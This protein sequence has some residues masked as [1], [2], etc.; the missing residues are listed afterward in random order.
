MLDK[1]IFR[2][3]Y[4]KKR[5]AINIQVGQEEVRKILSALR[6]MPLYQ[7]SRKIFTYYSVGS[8]VDTKEL[9]RLALLE[10]KEIYLPVCG[11]NH[12]MAIYKI[13]SLTDIVEG[14]YHIPVPADQ[15]QP[16]RP[17]ELDLTIVPGLCFDRQGYRIGYG[18]GYYDRFLPKI[19]PGTAVGFCYSSLLV[20]EVPR[21]AYD[22]K[23]DWVLT[24]DEVI[25]L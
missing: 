8:E 4:R 16:L 12:T 18:G 13:H 20:P 10:G 1:K 6:E 7:S 22:R 5:D 19:H 3:S 14:A 9:I 17:E 2:Q 21:D 24:G 15:S 11:K 23:C 25:A